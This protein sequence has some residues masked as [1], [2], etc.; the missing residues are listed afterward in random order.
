MERISFAARIRSGFETAIRAPSAEG[1]WTEAR[2]REPGLVELSFDSLADH[3]RN[4]S[5]SA[6]PMAWML[7]TAVIRSYRRGPR[8]VWAPVLLEMLAPAVVATAAE[9]RYLPPG[10]A[11]EDVQQQLVA[12][13]LRAASV[14]RL[15]AEAPWIKRQIVMR[16]RGRVSRWLRAEQQRSSE[17][18]MRLAPSER[19]VPLWPLGLE[20]AGVD[21]TDLVLVY[22]ARVLGERLAD[23]ALS[24]GVTETAMRF[25]VQRA[26]A[27]LRRGL[28]A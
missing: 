11:E 12:E 4:A 18:S 8:E 6:A 20:G 15:H 19:R 3:T 17:P 1:A 26:E 9:F 7:L 28:A 22:R 16:A 13:V 5:P 10:V 23:M 2:E 24:T 14:T 21:R 27:R 25:R